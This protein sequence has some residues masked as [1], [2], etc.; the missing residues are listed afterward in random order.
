MPDLN[1]DARA[2]IAAFLPEAIMAALDSY[3]HFLRAG[4]DESKDGDQAKNFKAHHDAC[5]VAIAH[6]ELLIKLGKSL[7]IDAQ[8]EADAKSQVLAAM[9]KNA[10]AEIGKHEKDNDDDD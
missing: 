6:L 2:R 8:D 10:E 9:L 3:H 5:K 1:D 7:D 4:P